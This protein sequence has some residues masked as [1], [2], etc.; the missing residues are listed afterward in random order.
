MSLMTLFLL[1]H[2][3]NPRLNKR[4]RLAKE[5]GSAE[6]VCIRRAQADLR[7][8]EHHDVPHHIFEQH[9]PDSGRILQ[10]IVPALRFVRYAYAHMRKTRPKCIYVSGF[11]SLIAASL[12]RVMK[13]KT[14]LIS[15]VGDLRELY[16]RDSFLSKRI[17]LTLNK[18]LYARV[19]LLVITSEKFYEQYYQHL[20]SRE[21]VVVE[22][23]I[24]VLDA[25]KS[26][27]R[28]SKGKYTVGFIGAVRYIEQ[29]KM[30]IKST[31][32][33]PVDVLIA[34]GGEND[35][36]FDEIKRFSS[37]YTHVRI[38]GKYNY[39]SD[40]ADLYGAIDC[41]YA[42]YDADLLNVRI[43]LPNRL[44]EAAYCGLPIIVAKR[45]Y[46]SDIVQK[47]SLGYAVEHDNE[48]ELTAVIQNLLENS[49]ITD[50]FEHAGRA[51]MDTIAASGVDIH[52]R[53]LIG[54]DA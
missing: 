40:I 44:Y 7:E 17:L 13:P 15:E 37:S 32:R 22:H 19:S 12:Y 36:V 16:T 18:V 34:G 48:A 3:P 5:I 28:K 26:Y 1:T 8:K 53:R 6:V 4:I 2:M 47:Y 50:T 33:L 38:T 27:V 23:N 11:E 25:F 35:S 52:L 20:I 10:R 54:N 21:K 9:Y 51:F 39:S 30:L 31:A 14:I 24:P 49:D 29:L 46:L 41:V 43:A 45:T 42:V